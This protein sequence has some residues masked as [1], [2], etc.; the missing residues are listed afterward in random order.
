MRKKP[1]HRDENTAGEARP[2]LNTRLFWGLIAAFVAVDAIGLM[3]EGLSVVP[4]P[5]WDMTWRI[6]ALIALSLFYTRFRPDARLATLMHAIAMFSATATPISIFYY[7]ATAWHYPLVD[8]HLAAA[9]HALGL[10]WVAAY[11]WVAALPPLRMVLSIAYFSLL[12]QAFILIFALN[13]LGKVERCWELPWLLLVAGIILIPFSIFTPA[14]GAFGYFHVNESEAYVQIFRG[15][16]DGT[17]KTIDFQTMQGVVQFPSLHAASAIMIAYAARSIRFLFPFY[18]LL[19]ALMFLATPPLGGHYFADVFGGAV[20]A[21]VT[22]MIVR[23]YCG[24]LLAPR[25]FSLPEPA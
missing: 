14:V 16:Y 23:K 3:T 2:I 5:L 17:L 8:A 13:F 7:L 1:K 21:A 24:P 15:L 6:A 12:P 4:E 25:S 20:L 22:I 9:D 18:V 19:N 11:R 10:D